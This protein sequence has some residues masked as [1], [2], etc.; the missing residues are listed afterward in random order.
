MSAQSSDRRVVYSSE[1][2]SVRYCRRCGQPAHEGR[3]R[4]PAAST[5]T[6]SS[7]AASRVPNDGI[8]RIARSKQ[9]RGGKTVT[10]TMKGWKFSNGEVV[11]ADSVK[12]FL[13]MAV[14]E[15]ANWYAYAPGLLPDNVTSYTASGNTYTAG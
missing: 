3:C 12:F 9:G 5:A 4:V 15:K 14:A 1:S 11:N 8:V 6:D 13:N 7:S 10:V 2:G